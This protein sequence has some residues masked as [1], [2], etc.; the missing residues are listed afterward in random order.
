MATVTGAPRIVSLIPSATEILDLI[1]VT[2]HLVGRSHECDTPAWVQS[3]PECTA[4]AFSTEGPE[5]DVHDRVAARLQ[6]ALSIYRLHVPVIESL[7]PTHIV[8]Q[9]RCDVCAVTL[10]EVETAACAL[11]GGDTKVIALA[12]H[13]LADVWS[14]IAR[15]AAMFDRDPAV[16]DHCAKR[17]A[18]LARLTAGVGE[19]PTV[20]CLEWLDP[21][22][23]AG[24]WLPEL[25]AV[26]GGEAVL[27]HAGGDAERLDHNAL[28]EA[29]PDVIVCMPCGHD[30]ARTRAGSA[31][32]IAQPGF[33]SLRAV[34]E[35]RVH[36]VDGSHFFS[37]PGPRLLESAEILAEILFPDRFDFGHRGRHWQPVSDDAG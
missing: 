29:D 4:P 11:L 13:R 34:R 15:L 26:A 31:T 21:L 20:A 18:R 3:L 7:A 2:D 22:I 14:D 8:T 30:L 12:P 32:L 25:V 36:A 27:A 6:Q 33:E 10:R 1:G 5:R 23:G 35:G 17:C 16:A 37:R 28:L 19:R 9:D 24:G